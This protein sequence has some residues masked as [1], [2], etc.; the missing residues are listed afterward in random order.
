MK[1]K[2]AY[3][4]RSQR[5]TNKL[6][7]KS[8]EIT[9]AYKIFI[10]RKQFPLCGD[11]RWGREMTNSRKKRK[12]ISVT[13]AKKSN[14]FWLKSFCF[15][16]KWWIECSDILFRSS[17]VNIWAWF[18]IPTTPT[19]FFQGSFSVSFSKCNLHLRNVFRKHSSKK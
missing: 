2:K 17:A 4:P 3:L 12:L 1:K 14:C 9:S 15:K 7:T 16:G 8:K 11:L 13:K 6:S 18:P 5:Q 19:H 10:F